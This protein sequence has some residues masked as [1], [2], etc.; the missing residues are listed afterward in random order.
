MKGVV[1]ISRFKGF[2]PYIV[3]FAVSQAFLFFSVQLEQ[4]PKL[5]LS[6]SAWLVFILLMR[7][8]LWDSRYFVYDWVRNHWRHNTV[9]IF[10]FGDKIEDQDDIPGEAQILSEIVA[11][12]AYKI[13]RAIYFLLLPLIVVSTLFITG[14]S[15]KWYYFA[16]AIQLSHLIFANFY[17][18]LHI[19]LNLGFFVAAIVHLG[20]DSR[21]YLF[22]GVYTLLYFATRVF[23]DGLRMEFEDLRQER[24]KVRQLK[25]RRLFRSAI[26]P[27]ILLTT[28]YA[29]LELLLPRLDEREDNLTV[30]ERL[31][32]GVADY[33]LG[34]A[35]EPKGQFDAGLGSRAKHKGEGLGAQGVKA[36]TPDQLKHRLPMDVTQQEADA[37]N[38][39]LPGRKKPDSSSPEMQRYE[40]AEQAQELGL[41]GPE[42]QKISDKEHLPDRRLKDLH[43]KYMASLG[44]SSG[45]MGNEDRA[46]FEKLLR[47]MSKYRDA[48]FEDIESAK[49][50]F[51]QAQ[52]EAQQLNQPPTESEQLAL[53]RLGLGED[54]V[55]RSRKM[56]VAEVAAATGL[57]GDEWESPES[58][59][60]DRKKE[61]AEDLQRRLGV[62]VPPA[63]EELDQSLQE[64]KKYKDVSALGRAEAQDLRRKELAELQ[65]QEAERQA[66]AEELKK[67]K[68][69]QAEAER[70]KK[71]E[72]EKA[73]EEQK[74]RLEA[75]KR[76]KERTRQLSL[77]EAR[78]LRD[79]ADKVEK[80][81]KDQEKRQSEKVR[82]EQKVAFGQA[83]EREKQRL[84][85]IKKE[86]AEIELAKVESRLR[87]LQLKK[88]ESSGGLT[89]SEQQ[90]LIALQ[91]QLKQMKEELRLDDGEGDN[92][93]GKQKDLALAP[94]DRA[95]LA[96]LQKNEVAESIAEAQAEMI[97][98][99]Q[100]VA[101]GKA[102]IEDR[103]KLAELEVRKK[104]QEQ[105]FKELAEKEQDAKEVAEAE[106]FG[107]DVLIS[108][109]KQEL[110]KKA[111]EQ[112]LLEKS[113]TATGLSAAEK[114]ALDNLQRQLAEIQSKE[115]HRRQEAQKLKEKQA[116]GAMTAKD[117]VREVEL[118]MDGLAK[119]IASTELLQDQLKKTAVSEKNQE[120]ARL[121]SIKA[122]QIEQ[123]KNL[124]H[125]KERLLAEQLY[126]EAERDELL[127]QGL[128]QQRSIRR[129]NELYQRRAQGESLNNDELKELARLA[130]EVAAINKKRQ[131]NKNILKELERRARRRE[132]GLAEEVSR[133]QAEV[134][135]KAVEVGEVSH[136][137]EVAENSGQLS[138]EQIESLRATELQKTDQLAQAQKKLMDV[139][140]EKQALDDERDARVQE[141]LEFERLHGRY[142]ELKAKQGEGRLT[143]DEALELE[144]LSPQVGKIT[145][146]RKAQ[147]KQYSLL[148][149]KLGQGRLPD[150]EGDALTDLEIDQVVNRLAAAEY[151]AEQLAETEDL[152]EEA[153]QTRKSNV[154]NYLP[155]FGE[156]P[157]FE[158]PEAIE[159]A[160]GIMKWEF[161]VKKR[162]KHQV[163]ASASKKAERVALEMKKDVGLAIYES[164]QERRR[165][166]LKLKS[167]S[168]ALSP[169]ES[170]E[171]AKLD[172]AVKK[173]EEKK[174]AEAKEKDELQ[175]KKEEKLKQD[176]E[177]SEEESF[178]PPV[179]P[180][181]EKEDAT[182]KDP[183]KRK[184]EQMI[185]QLKSVMFWV[186][187]GLVVLILYGVIRF[188]S[189][190]DR[191]D[192]LDEIRQ[193]TLTHQ[194]LMQIRQ[195]LMGLKSKK[196][197]PREEVIETYRAM[198]KILAAVEFERPSFEPVSIYQRRVRDSWNYIEGDFRTVSERFVSTYYGRNEPQPDQLKQFRQASKK[199][200][201]HF[202]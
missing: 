134:Y 164:E 28:I 127:Q 108:E 135:E 190:V 101:A 44:R 174:K 41:T 12:R 96:E 177:K 170:N 129:Y 40:L 29:S 189:R 192:N 176:E 115:N 93:A 138:E 7:Q 139:Q 19:S 15:I 199:I 52:R 159:N 195:A 5:G 202:H 166:E 130:R 18:H 125:E 27:M 76:K 152:D 9:Y 116:L 55:A 141:Q 187:A 114:K 118:K 30:T 59:S 155:S 117:S 32:K 35:P 11:S 78:D 66:K 1:K 37:V 154:I 124:A 169:Q 162:K 92:E 188:L 91:R 57:E 88:E 31:A 39:M 97:R 83:T 180:E 87:E 185:S 33:V 98:L 104:E 26:M 181:M 198:E 119:E 70:Q 73:A 110:K 178:E 165:N 122:D 60:E 72:E 4:Q 151:A 186:L 126:L 63:P 42:W 95:R 25:F 90:Q 23:E 158:N 2:R 184:R 153:G 196:L 191:R 156:L 179:P 173:T 94:E 107:R 79:L 50:E 82:L 46:K 16:F 20:G 99:R 136:D 56:D 148:K 150:P 140:A 145:E 45:T 34:K 80:A 24:S 10:L 167:E 6:L 121:E 102:T 175:K 144:G 113:K 8:F 38:E 36:L 143:E 89:G 120:Q 65:K 75:L 131:Q 183:N 21:N 100:L 71:L 58:L 168:E 22:F 68:E 47:E 172:Q 149:Q 137:L 171:L 13:S 200:I 3:C 111:Q 123:L 85:E 14:I 17:R 147:A 74:K 53:R 61:V 193:H 112:Q 106:S 133:S 182:P 105:R 69:R 103:Q 48:T 163:E 84:E 197:S 109:K 194:Q 161:E 128:A 67:E 142:S 146:Q 51:Q 77:N 160:I 157:E 81:T 54:Q 86:E 62:Q 201:A 43:K 49:A 64:L 132:L